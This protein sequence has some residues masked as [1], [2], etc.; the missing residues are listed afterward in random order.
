M[1]K[2]T[3]LKRERPLLSP[4]QGL[5]W[6]YGLA[7]AALIGCGAAPGLGDPATSCWTP[8]AGPGL[9]SWEAAPG[10]SCRDSAAGNGSHRR[11]PG[12]GAAVKDP[13]ADRA[14]TVPGEKPR[15]QFTFSGN[16]YVGIAAVF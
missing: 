7:I 5:R 9:F 12:V 2:H 8:G 15:T 4:H 3:P 14:P 13:S 10:V 6:G 1:T 16:A 11:V